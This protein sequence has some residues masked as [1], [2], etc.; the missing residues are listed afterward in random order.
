MWGVQNLKFHSFSVQNLKYHSLFFTFIIF[1][2]LDWAQICHMFLD[3]TEVSA[4]KEC[5]SSFCSL[6][7]SFFC[8]FYRTAYIFSRQICTTCQALEHVSSF[9]NLPKLQWGG[10]FH[11]PFSHPWL[12]F[13]LFFLIFNAINL[14]LTSLHMHLIL[15]LVDST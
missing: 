12:F 2:M 14:Y 9:Q 6:G 11:F 8:S 4:C 10:T 3:F 1:F 15:I 5:V 7:C 13:F